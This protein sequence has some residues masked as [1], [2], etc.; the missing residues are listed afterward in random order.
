MTISVLFGIPFAVIGFLCAEPLLLLMNTPADVIEKSAL[1][2]R[3]YFVGLPATM[4]YNF[5]SA[6]L[7]AKG[8]TRFPLYTLTVSGMLNVGLNLLFVIVFN[9]DVAGVAW[10]T[11]IS[12]TLSAVLSVWRMM[13]ARDD[14]RLMLSKLGIR[15]DKFLR[16][17]R[18]GLPAGVQGRRS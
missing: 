4:I 14:C 7:R 13:T 18:I 17:V 6:I 1:Y 3:L 5:A 12:Q 16:I 10:A 11:V 9:M 2:M 15:K 8:D